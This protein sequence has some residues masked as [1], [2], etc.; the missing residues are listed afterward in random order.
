VTPQHAAPS[1]PGNRFR[2][3]S[4]TLCGALIVVVTG[5]TLSSGF[6]VKRLLLALVLTLPLWAPLRGLIRRDRRT[7]AWATLCVI[8]YFVLALTESIANPPGR[9]WSATCLGLALLLFVALIGYLRVTR[10]RT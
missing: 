6:S 9:G 7:Y 2:I 8:P 5:W 3:F 4:L 10:S 1:A